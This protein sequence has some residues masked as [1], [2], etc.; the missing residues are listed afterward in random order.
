MKFDPEE[1]GLVTVVFEGS[2]EETSYQA[3]KVYSFAKKHNGFRAGIEYHVNF[4][5]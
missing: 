2:E 3:K 1:M 4:R 5:C